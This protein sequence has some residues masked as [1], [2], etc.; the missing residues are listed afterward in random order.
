VFHSWWFVLLLSLLSAN[1]VVASIERFPAAWRYFSHPARRAEPHFFTSLAMKQA[2]PLRGPRVDMEKVELAFR[3]AGWKPQYVSDDRGSVSLYAERFRIARMAPFVVHASLLLILAGGII[4]AV[5][6]YKGFIALGQN[7]STNQLELRDGTHKALPFAIRCDGAGQENYADGTPKRWW[8]RLTVLE[9]GRDIRSKEIVVNDPLTYQ[10]L[11]FYQA[12]Y[13]ATGE[14][15]GVKLLATP[16]D[17]SPKQEFW[18][19]LDEGVALDQDATVRI[20]QFIPDF[21][22]VENHIESRSDQPV[23][24]AV[25]ISVQS[26]RAGENKIWLFPK[27]PEFAHGNNTGFDFRVADLRMGYFTGLEVSHEPGQWAVWAGV[28]L[29]GAALALVFYFVHLRLWALP[30]D[31]GQGRLVLWLGAS[32]SKNREDFERRFRD[33]ADAVEQDLQSQ[34]SAAKLERAEMMVIK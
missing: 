30:V 19:K 29:M 13:G 18:L 27:F 17:G 7:E 1:I 5:W 9:N 2:I 31:D 23:N 32:A 16:K 33:L 24:P 14:V 10:G 12:S 22:V 3:R 4:D 20:A 15:A 34:T 28:V 21:V 6:G 8:S 25:Q 26:K 11:R